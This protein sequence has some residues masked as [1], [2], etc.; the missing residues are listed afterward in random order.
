M[1]GAVKVATPEPSAAARRTWK[2]GVAT[3]LEAMRGGGA[4]PMGCGMVPPPSA[5]GTAEDGGEPVCHPSR[6]SKQAGMRLTLPEAPSQHEV[7]TARSLR[8]HLE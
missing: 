3:K 6:Q 4:P 5:L 2:N 1:A 8:P 7:G